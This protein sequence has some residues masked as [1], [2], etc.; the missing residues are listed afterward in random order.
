MTHFALPSARRLAGRTMIELIIAMAIGMVILIGVGALYLSSSGVSRV[1]N[2]AGSAEDTGRIVMTMIGEGIKAGGYGEIVGSDYSAQGQTLFDGAVVRGCS[3]SRFADAFNVATPDYTCT[4]AAPGDQVVFRFQGR[5]AL[6]PMDA[7]NLAN[8]ALPDCLGASNANQD[9]QFN[10]AT[11]RAGAG[12]TRRVVQSA[13]S[14]D[15]TGTVLRCE[16]NGNP[17]IPTPIVNDMIDFRVFYRFDDGGYAL[18]AGNNTN[19]APVGGSIRDATW[20]NTTAAGPENAEGILLPAGRLIAEGQVPAGHPQKAILASYTKEYEARFKQPTS[21]FGG[22][23]WDAIML[24][25]QGARRAQS[26]EP[27]AIRDAL[28]ATRG[29]WGTTGE[30]NFSAED[31]AGLTEDAFVMV[32]ITKGNWEMLR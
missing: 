6:V 22:Y 29:F 14:L 25:A 26:A 11:P 16:G 19:Y 10:P 21:T 12:T 20:I 2:Q 3:G 28:E 17:G 30:Y 1:A 18:A 32:R 7:A 9:L 4:G 5:Y 8:A 27:A 15:A 24:V 13:F 31:H 23:A